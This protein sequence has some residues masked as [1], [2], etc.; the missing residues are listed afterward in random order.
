MVDPERKSLMNDDTRDENA[1]R[2]LVENWASAV[3]R[4]DLAGILLNHSANVLMFDVPP[5]LASNGIEAYRKTWDLFFSWAHDPVV[6]DISQMDITAG[7]DVAFV[8]A[9]MRCAGSEANRQ[10][11]ELNFRLTIGLQKIDDQW[12]VVHEHHSIPATQ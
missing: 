3:R 2:E 4:K 9:L 12:V 5:P 10:V 1:I 11:I 6:F 8:T 7:D